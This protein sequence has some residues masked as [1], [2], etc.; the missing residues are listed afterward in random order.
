M[1]KKLLIL[2]LSALIGFFPL[3]SYG[4]TIISE[5]FN[6]YNNGDLD[7]QGDWVK[8]S[9][10][11][12]VRGYTT[13]NP[14][15]S[16]KEI[17][18][19]GTAADS[20]YY[21]IGTAQTDG[22]I[23]FYERKKLNNE[24]YTYFILHDGSDN[25]NINVMFNSS[26]RIVYR[27]GGVWNDLQGYSA[28]TWYMIEIEWRSSDGKVRYQIDGGGWTDWVNKAAAGTPE[29][30]ALYHSHASVND[31]V[32]VDYIMENPYEE[33]EPPPAGPTNF[34]FGELLMVILAVFVLCLII[35]KGGEKLIEAIKRIYEYKI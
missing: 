23:T 17:Y 5:D 31:E 22:R 4:A 33:E 19:G 3:I 12:S 32:S 15:G 34:T 30:V 28:D 27:G 20:D 6:S 29:K 14:E 13:G 16:G 9:N 7:G 18:S 8:T 24:G 26:G 35:D 1:K 25:Y 21:I 10:T 11:I 2:S